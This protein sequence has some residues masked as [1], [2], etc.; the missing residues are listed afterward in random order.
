MG[1]RLRRR[2]GIVPALA[3]VLLLAGPDL[4]GAKKSRLPALPATGLSI[5]GPG[6]MVVPRNGR[7][8]LAWF[9]SPISVCV[10]VVAEG[11]LSVTLHS[12]TPQDVQKTGFPPDDGEAFTLCVADVSDV[13]VQST[14]GARLR[15]RVDQLEA[16]LR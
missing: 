11:G 7:R 14:E 10:T 13:E 16:V 1:T 5:G 12:L 3:V 15:W 9:D 8:I 6:E 4:A 2:A